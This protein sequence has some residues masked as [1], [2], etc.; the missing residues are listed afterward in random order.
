MVDRMVALSLHGLPKKL[1]FTKRLIARKGFEAVKWDLAP[2]EGEKNHLAAARGG[3]CYSLTTPEK[4]T[5]DLLTPFSGVSSNY[6][7]KLLAGAG[8]F[9]PPN[10][11]SKDPC[12]AA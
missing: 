2:E 5:H 1:V 10:A 9:E 6:Y 4:L 8:G 11:G 12:L 7:N 3:R